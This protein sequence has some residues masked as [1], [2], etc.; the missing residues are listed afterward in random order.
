MTYTKAIE[1]FMAG[2]NRGYEYLYYSTYNV[3]KWDIA[4]ILGNEFDAEDV[5]QNAYIKMVDK[6]HTLENPEK[7]PAWFNRLA[8]NMAIDVWRSQHGKRKGDNGDSNYRREVSFSEFEQVDGDGE[9]VEYEWEDESIAFRPE[10]VYTQKETVEL[11]HEMLNNLSEEQKACLVMFHLQGLSI[12]EIAEDMQISENTVKSRLNYARKNI[13]AQGEALKKKGYQLYSVAPL[14]LLLYLLRMERGVAASSDAYWGAATVNGWMAQT[15]ETAAT[16]IAQATVDTGT[17]VAR[18]F[19]GTLGGKIAVVLGSVAVVAVGAIAI[20]KHVKDKDD[21][22]STEQVTEEITESTQIITE[23]TTEAT[24]EVVIDE[25]ELLV[26]YYQDTLVPEY[27]LMPEYQANT[28]GEACISGIFCSDI[29]DYNQDG[30]L[31]LYV[32]YN[33][34]TE[35]EEGDESSIGFRTYNKHQVLYT[36]EENQVVLKSDLVEECYLVSLSVPVGYYVPNI[37]AIVSLYREDRKLWKISVDGRIYLFEY[38]TGGEWRDSYHRVYTY[39]TDN[40]E[41][42]KSADCVNQG[43]DAGYYSLYDYESGEIASEYRLKDA[44]VQYEGYEHKTLEEFYGDLGI[45][46]ICEN[47]DVSSFSNDNVVLF[48]MQCG[49][50]DSG[51]DVSLWFTGVRE[52]VENTDENPNEVTE[53]NSYE[54]ELLKAYFQDTLVAQYGLMPE[55]N[56]EI[57]NNVILDGIYCSDID[58]Y[59]GDGVLDLFVCRYYNK[60]NYVSGGT[61]DSRTYVEYKELYSIDNGQ[62]VLFDYLETEEVFDIS[63][64]PGKS[65]IMWKVEA[66]NKIYLVNYI[67]YPWAREMSKEFLI[68]EYNGNELQ[69]ARTLENGPGVDEDLLYWGFV[70]EDGERTEPRQ[71]YGPE[72]GI[73]YYLPEDYAD[74]ENITEEDFMAE[75]GIICDIDGSVRWDIENLITYENENELLC[76]IIHGVDGG[77]YGEVTYKNILIQ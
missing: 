13:E 16:G 31:D 53:D 77:N 23:E 39:G 6:L 2:D 59:N 24:T 43:E 42:V 28:Q 69:I 17:K 63:R 35:I 32:M 34:L 66:N 29:D 46:V 11:V 4:K 7:F 54:I 21:T 65:S 44:F 38:M 8:T 64:Y 68:F 50:R 60:N 55:Y 61:E 73:G 40:F 37:G 56:N 49:G 71:L 76:N 41:L 48:E 70:Y 9:T 5:L 18:G 58:D 14:P 25:R 30:V 36:V 74:A 27:G 75:I 15:A 57:L 12:K 47:N 22:P 20:N 52:T 3:N 33:E 51:E 45:S 67:M 19:L 1:M 10:E 26:T 72:N 62:V